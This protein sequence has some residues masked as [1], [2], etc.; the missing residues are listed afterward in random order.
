MSLPADTRLG[1]FQII[2]GLGSGGMGEVYRARDVRLGREVALKIVSN[3]SADAQALERFHREARA[4]SALNHPNICTVYEVGSPHGGPSYLAMELL[5]GETLQQRLCRGPL[6]LTELLDIGVGIADALD[7]AHAHG[8]IHRDLKPSNVFLTAHGPKLL[9]FGIA[10]ISA[11]EGDDTVTAG[12]RLTSPGSMVGTVA[13]MSPEQL[14]GLPV[15]P[16]SDL[17]SMGLLLYE[18]ATGRP[19]FDGVTSALLSASILHEEPSR[20]SSHRP[21]LPEPIEAVI[22]KALEKDRDLRCQSAAELRADLRRISRAFAAGAATPG[23]MHPV[24]VLPSATITQA[25]AGPRRFLWLLSAVIIVTAGGLAISWIARGS[26]RQGDQLPAKRETTLRQMT[27]DGGLTTTPAMSRDGRLIAYAS[28]RDAEQLDLWVQQVAGG[29]PLRITRHAADDYDPVFSPDGTTITFRSDRDGGGIYQVSALG[30]SEKLL[31]AR[32]RN[33]RVS[34]DGKWVVY[35]VGSAIGG[36]PTSPGSARLFL[37]ESVG[38]VA[39]SIASEF[40]A[41]RFPISVARWPV[42]DVP[43]EPR[44]DQAARLVCS[45]RHKGTGE[46]PVRNSLRLQG[47]LRAAC[48]RRMGR[49]LLDLFRARGRRA[50]SLAG[51]VRSQDTR[52][53]RETRASDSRHR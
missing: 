33:P 50:G 18:M 26:R 46:V 5:T 49:G 21:D 29:E 32:G 27:R 35:R 48:C 39:R 6:S 14:A 45:T 34:P 2:A 28:D 53:R 52:I 40:A 51:A 12:A 8:I 38:G 42:I 4:A 43:G 23:P 25:G 17:F 16:R 20:P 31:A 19:A 22:L 36:D 7:A 24:P 37:I 15:D 13:Y 1:P 30:G 41:A 9:D 11:R 10:K 47:R 3:Q 44:A